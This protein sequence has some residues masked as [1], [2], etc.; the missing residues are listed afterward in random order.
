MMRHGL[1]ELVEGKL[2]SP[3]DK[4]RAASRAS[5]AAVMA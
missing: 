2:A 3:F 5:Y 1:P 4:L